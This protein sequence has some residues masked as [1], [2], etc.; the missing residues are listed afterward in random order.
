MPEKK[1]LHLKFNCPESLENMDKDENGF[2]CDSCS[3]HVEDHRDKSFEELVELGNSGKAHCGVFNRNQLIEYWKKKGVS[4]ST[5]HSFLSP[6]LELNV[7][8]ESHREIQVPSAGEEK[9]CLK[10]KGTVRLEGSLLPGA[11]IFLYH[12]ENLIVGLTT[13]PDGAYE[14]STW[15]EVNSKIKLVANYPGYKPGQVKLRTKQVSNASLTFDFNLEEPDETRFHL[16]TPILFGMV[17]MEYLD[18]PN[19]GDEPD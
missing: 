4:N 5:I 3:K 6:K 7:L 19:K 10:F 14:F 17:D 2:H 15:V 18:V 9:A 13:D 12:K 1:I 11:E 8:N 16:D